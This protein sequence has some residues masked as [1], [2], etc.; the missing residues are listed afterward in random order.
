MQTVTIKKPQCCA[1]YDSLGN[2]IYFQQRKTT[3]IDFINFY[4]SR[5]KACW[6]NNHTESSIR[7]VWLFWWRK[8][9]SFRFIH[10]CRYQN[11]SYLLHLENANLKRKKNTLNHRFDSTFVI[12]YEITKMKSIVIFDVK[13]LYMKLFRKIIFLFCVIT[14]KSNIQK[15]F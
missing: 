9:Y 6:F 15:Y 1:Q 2:L 14:K 13:Q 4:L 3:V 10:S 11:I 8:H 7:W 12:T 5:R